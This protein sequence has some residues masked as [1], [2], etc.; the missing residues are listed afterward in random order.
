MTE[1]EITERERTLLA[2]I[3][4]NLISRLAHI[5]AAMADKPEGKAE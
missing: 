1:T 2:Q 4:N 3:L 5:R